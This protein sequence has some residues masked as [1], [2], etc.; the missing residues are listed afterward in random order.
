[1]GLGLLSNISSTILEL[2]WKRCMRLISQCTNITQLK[3]IHAIFITHGYHHNNYALSKLIYFSSFSNSPNLHYASL[4]FHHTPNPNSFIY[5]TLIRAYSS[6]SQPLYTF[7]YFHLMVKDHSLVPDHHTFPFVLIA[8]VKTCSVLLGEGVHGCLVKNGLGY[9]DNHIQTALL[10]FYIECSSSLWDAKKVFDEIPQRDAVHWN[11]FMKGCLRYGFYSEAVGVFREM[12]CSNVEPDEYCVATGLTA[13]ANSGAL[14]QGMWVHEY[15]K[16]KGGFFGD[17]FVGTVLVDMYAKCG[18]IEKAVEV[19]EGMPYR[20][21]FSWAAMIGGFAVHGFAKEAIQCL[22][23]MVREN[24]RPDN[25]V[26]LAVLTACTHAGLVA[27]GLFLLENMNALYG[28]VPEIEHYSCTADLLCRA[29]R[30]NEA[31]ELIHRMPMK[32]LAGV[33]GSMLSACKKYGNVELAELAVEKLL[34]IERDT[35]SKEDIVYI[36]LSNIYL[37]AQRGYEARRIRKMMGDRGVK[38]TPGCSVIE[39]NGEVHEFVAGDVT[40]PLQVLLHGI[41]NLLSWQIYGHSCEY[42]QMYTSDPL[43]EDMVHDVVE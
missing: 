38:K 27:E 12:L 39:V 10:R 4:L 22:D 19:F 13:C 34:Q 42:F 2:P 31:L 8:C 16:K 5:N 29:G 21:V 1:M 25:I 7:H 3:I 17:V 37:N 30:L 20:N 24:Q 9:A 32:P 36:Q 14:H 28:I 26:L 40:H 35:G 6:S 18:C 33:W 23:R 15:V 41:L 43:M 11:V